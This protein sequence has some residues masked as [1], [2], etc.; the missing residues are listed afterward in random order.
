MLYDALEMDSTP[1]TST[2]ES[3]IFEEF[4]FTSVEHLSWIK[5]KFY[6]M[7][8]HKLTFIKHSKS[9]SEKNIKESKSDVQGLSEENINFENSRNKTYEDLLSFLLYFS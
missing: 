2:G 3:K 5:A 7:V 1:S 8:L 4:V 9:K 6:E